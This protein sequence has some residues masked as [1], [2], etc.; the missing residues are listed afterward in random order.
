MM[1]KSVI[2]ILGYKAKLFTAD[3]IMQLCAHLKLTGYWSRSKD[4]ALRIVTA[5]KIH[6][7]LYDA[8]EITGDGAEKQPTKTNSCIFLF[9]QCTFF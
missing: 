1:G 7:K 9:N 2:T 8:T 5:S 6:S 4:E 3:Q